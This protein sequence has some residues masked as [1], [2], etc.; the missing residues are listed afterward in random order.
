MA[1]SLSLGAGCKKKC[2]SSCPTKAAKTAKADKAVKPGKAGK[3]AAGPSEALKNVTVAFVTNNPSEFWA[4]ARKGVDQAVSEIG[5]TVDFRIPANGT[6]AEQQQIVEDLIAKGCKGMAIS[7]VDPKN[8]TPMLDKASESMLVICHDSDAPDSKRL[9]YI[10]TNNYTAGKEAG[11]L[12]KE[13]LP[14][15][16][17]IMLF[18]GT[19]DA[20]NARDRQQGILDEL[21]G[22]NVEVMDTRTDNTDRTKA[23]TNVEDTIVNNPDVACLVGLW[24][25]NGPAIAQA[26]KESGKQGKIQV[27]CFDEEDQTLQAI[28]DG[29]IY[30]TVVQK[31]YQ[32]GYQSVRVLASLAT[33]DT[34]IIPENKI[35]DTGVTLVKADTVDAFWAELK[36]LTGK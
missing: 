10:G 15:G 2:A 18:V 24:S 12:I 29:V 5:V 33:G 19:L 27:V 1:I 32:F 31:P 28:K 22:S 9:A 25:Y 16:G 14:K 20:Q 21:Q 7:P 13:A 34:T 36:S 35:I 3:A 23:K 11:K 4:I 8:Q 17:K 30:A 6:A 26:V